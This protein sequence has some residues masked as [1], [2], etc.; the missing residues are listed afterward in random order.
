MKT[1]IFLSALQKLRKATIS[2]VVTV[3][4]YGKNSAPNGEI[5]MK[6]NI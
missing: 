1:N 2:S 6:F 4:P 5:F 3:S